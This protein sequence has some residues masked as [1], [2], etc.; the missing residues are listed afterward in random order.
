MRNL[1]NGRSR[2]GR[3]RYF[4]AADALKIRWP[5]VCTVGIAGAA[6]VIFAAVALSL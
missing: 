3:V 1:F 4:T 5:L 2:D 6:V